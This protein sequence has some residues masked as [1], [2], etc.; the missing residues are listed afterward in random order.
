M[1]YVSYGTF[2]AAL[3]LTKRNTRVPPLEIRRDGPFFARGTYQ[4]T[5]QHLR[6]PSAAMF[7]A[8]HHVLWLPALADL[9][10]CVYSYSHTYG[11]ARLR[12]RTFYPGFPSAVRARRHVASSPL[13]SAQTCLEKM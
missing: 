1:K 10:S 9:F 4:E 6:I 13:P 2:D 11:L 3:A 12:R 7:M 8:D 5:T